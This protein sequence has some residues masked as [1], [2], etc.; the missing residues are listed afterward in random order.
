MSTD[1]LVETGSVDLLSLLLCLFQLY[2][3]QNPLREFQGSPGTSRGQSVSKSMSQAIWTSIPG[4]FYLLSGPSN[5]IPTSAILY[6]ESKSI[7]MTAQ[8]RKVV[9]RNKIKTRIPFYVIIM[10]KI[11]FKTH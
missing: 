2:P 11:I 8:D 3:P 4:Q 1:A 6:H 9:S 10:V 7:S 5:P